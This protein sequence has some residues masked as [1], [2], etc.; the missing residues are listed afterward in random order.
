MP[1]LVIT[2]ATRGIGHAL[3]LVLGARP[4]ARL[5]LV[6]R[7]RHRLDELIASLPRAVGVPGD[8]GSIAG[9]R[10]LAQRL[11]EVLE[12][13][14]TLV[15]N[16]GLWPAKRTLTPDGLEEAFVVNH[17]APLA[18]QRALLPGAKVRRVMVV[19]AGL[20][21]LGRFDRERTPRGDDFSALGTY[22][23]T[24]LCFAIAMRELAREHP[25]LD[26]VALHPGVVRTDLGGRPGLLGRLLSLGKIGLESPEKCAQRLARILARPRWSPPGQAVWLDKEKPRPWP[27]ASLG[28]ATVKDVRE[29]SE[30]LL[31]AR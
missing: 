3:A 16:A 23:A 8:L 24:K 9:A 12:S 10:S 27:K 15:H 29:V 11:D 26:V 7:D 20:I 18:M 5:V 13:G 6:G 31:A 30:A 2:G 1:D 21:A 17:L 22:C 28:E 25:E 19:S 4:D 14:A